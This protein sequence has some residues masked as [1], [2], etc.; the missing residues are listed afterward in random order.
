MSLLPRI[1]LAMLACYR[2]SQLVAIDDGPLY[3]FKDLRLMLGKW[4]ASRESKRIG[5]R[6]SLAELL[7]C[8]FCLGVWFSVPLTAIILF[9][10][11]VFDAALIFLAVA[12]AQTFLQEHSKDSDR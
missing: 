2:L 10:N 9:P 1:F 11:A 7:T 5:W 12:G 4:A 3:I 6:H 8:P